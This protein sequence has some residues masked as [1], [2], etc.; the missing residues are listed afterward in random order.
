MAQRASQFGG[1]KQRSESLTA[2]LRSLKATHLQ[3]QTFTTFFAIL[4]RGGATNCS[5]N[6]V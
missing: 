6:V 4:K 3:F 2:P 5:S 1:A